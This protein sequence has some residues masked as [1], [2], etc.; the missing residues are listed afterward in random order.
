MNLTGIT[1]S[2]HTGRLSLSLSLT[3]IYTMIEED[4]KVEKFITPKRDLDH[5]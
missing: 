5:L 2:L 3:F 4:L 1:M